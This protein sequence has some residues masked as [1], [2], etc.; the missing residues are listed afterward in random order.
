MSTQVGAFL[1]HPTAWQEINW[2][3]C[4]RTVARLQARIVKATQQKKWGK[5]HALQ[6]TLTHS[7]SAKAIAVRRV[8]ENRGRK[9]PGID[10]QTWSTPQEK[11]KAITKLKRRGYQPKPVRR[12]YIPKASGKLR[13]LGIPT[14]QDRAMQALYLQS[15]DPIAETMA[16]RPSYGFRS[17]RSTADAIENCHLVLSKRVSAPWILEGDIQSC[18]DQIDHAWLVS[19]IPIDKQVLKKWLQAGYMERGQYKPSNRGTQQGSII[20]PLLANMALDGLEKKLKSCKLLKD[21]KVNLVRYADDFIITGASRQILEEVVRPLIAAFLQER[22]LSLSDKKTKVVHIQ[23]GFDFLGQNIR[24]YGQKLLVKPTKQSCMSLL[25]QV[26]KKLRTNRTATSCQIVKQL[27]PLLRGWGYYHRHVVSKDIFFKMDHL[28]GYQMWQWCKRR[29][30]R[31]AKAWIKR[32]YFSPGKNWGIFMGIE[33]LPVGET[34]RVPI[35]RLGEISI[36][37][38]PKVKKEA[39]PYDPVW[40]S[41]FEERQQRQWKTS[42]KSKGLL[43]KIWQKQ[44]GSCP[45]CQ[46]L[47][48]IDHEWDQ[49]HIQP[50]KEGGEDKLENLMLLHP[51]CHRQLHSQT[52]EAHPINIQIG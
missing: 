16:D 50:K 28:I 37:R 11:T 5:V 31:K 9:T 44:K 49:H 41:Y 46:Q 10:G 36:I 17:Q 43:L 22:G 6:W 21:R 35:Q 4:Y 42:S 40:K 30:P 51:T 38:H 3:A 2:P 23:E 26:K 12:I 48:E 14:M 34:K 24:K 15:L 19:H 52:K 20:S 8:T 18:F 13:P 25:A 47:I 45:V 1:T 7:F 39:N 29:H 32:K 33:K 27:N